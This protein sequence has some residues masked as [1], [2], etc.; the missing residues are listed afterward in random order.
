MLL[1][2]FAA[3]VALALVQ[4]I[5]LVDGGM[6]RARLPL[7]LPGLAGLVVAG[8]ALLDSHILGVGY[9]ATS[10]AL[11]GDYRCTCCCC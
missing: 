9:E 2:L 11:A 7:W 3:A 4:A 5:Y 1:G 6:R 10:A 8:L